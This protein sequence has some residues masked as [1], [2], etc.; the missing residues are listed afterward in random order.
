M[1]DTWPGE[2]K[3]FCSFSVFTTREGLL[4]WY[5]YR[6]HTVGK[7]S[8]LITF[9]RLSCRG[10]LDP[11][12]TTCVTGPHWH[13]GFS[14]SHVEPEWTFPMWNKTRNNQGT[15]IILPNFPFLDGI[16]YWDTVCLFCPCVIEAAGMCRQ[17]ALFRC[18]PALG[19]SSKPYSVSPVRQTS[20]PLDLS[21]PP[22]W[23]PK[24][25]L[26]RPIIFSPKPFVK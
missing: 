10:T 4:A 25:L 8:F 5:L 26:D 21:P 7:N 1:K 11:C 12:L 19:R 9:L 13:A 15:M 3:R 20:D 24:E 17:L 14:F 6:R 2:G 16:Y 18:K 22:I 23:Y